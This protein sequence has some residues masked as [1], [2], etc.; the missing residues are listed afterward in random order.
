MTKQQQQYLIILLLELSTVIINLLKCNH[1]SQMPSLI[2]FYLFQ[3]FLILLIQILNHN[4][5][6]FSKLLLNQNLS[7]D[8]IKE[9]KMFKYSIAKQKVKHV[10][11]FVLIFHNMICLRLL[12]IILKLNMNLVAK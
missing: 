2:M 8:K 10:L 5:N 9:T 1:H 7:K 3:I 12:L 6:F 4:L 11:K